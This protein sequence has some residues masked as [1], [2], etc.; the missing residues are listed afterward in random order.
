MQCLLTSCSVKKKGKPATSMG[1]DLKRAMPPQEE[2]Q[3]GPPRGIPE[4]GLAV[5]GDDHPTRALAPEALPGGQDGEA[6]G[7]DI[8]GPGPV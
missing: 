7:S 4:E 3:A 1:V 5:T 6:E 2:P 8:N